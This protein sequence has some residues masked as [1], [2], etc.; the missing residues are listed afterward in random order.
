M[1]TETVFLDTNGWFALLSNND[2]LHAS[3]QRSWRELARQRRPVVLT[4][5]I[6][7]ETGNGLARTPE[8]RGFP[9]AVR[10]LRNSA[11]T[12]IVT[13][14]SVLLERALKLYEERPDKTWGLVDCAS[15]VVMKDEGIADAFTTDRHFEQ[16]GFNCLLPAT[17][18]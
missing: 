13:A 17:A 9:F 11:R 3:A 16:A 4:D 7:A 14:T 12:R 6:I 10:E 8:R 2:V 5:W 15:F 1:A 18:P